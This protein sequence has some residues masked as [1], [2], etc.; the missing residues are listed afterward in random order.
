MHSIRGAL[1]QAAAT[2]LP[3]AHPTRQASLCWLETRAGTWVSEAS[4]ARRPR[5]APARAGARVSRWALLAD[6]AGTNPGGAWRRG[7]VA[8]VLSAGGLGGP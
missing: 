4:E 5:P 1:R 7:Q 3:T 6:W 2:D 8:A